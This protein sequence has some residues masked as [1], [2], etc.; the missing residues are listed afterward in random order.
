MGLRDPMSISTPVL[1]FRAG[2]L[3][4]ALSFQLS[5]HGSKRIG[6]SLH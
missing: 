2:A 1:V 6:N 5:S 3:E 4:K